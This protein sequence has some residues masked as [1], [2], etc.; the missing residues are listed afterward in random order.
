MCPRGWG[1]EGQGGAVLFDGQRTQTMQDEMRELDNNKAFSSE[2]L[3][4]VC[5]LTRIFHLALINLRP[6]PQ[7]RTPF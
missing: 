1:R 4:H 3:F 6:R 5:Y 2:K 7:K